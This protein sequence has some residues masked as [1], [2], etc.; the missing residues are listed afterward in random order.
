MRGGLGN[1]HSR[2]AVPDN[3]RRPTIALRLGCELAREEIGK[4]ATL[5]NAFPEI[6]RLHQSLNTEKC[7]TVHQIE[8]RAPPLA[9]HARR[10]YSEKLAIA[11]QQFREMVKQGICRPS[12]GSWASPILMKQKKD[13]T[14]RIC[15]DYHG[16]NADTE[17]DRYSVP[18]LQDFTANLHNKTIF[19]KLDLDKAYHQIPVAPEDISKTAVITPFG[20]FEYTVMTFGL[21]DAS[22]I[23][24]RYSFKDLRDL[25]YVFP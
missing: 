23:F 12:S 20:L 16:L 24:Q 19:S 6:T 25:P 3:R 15:G 1:L 17:P 5:L 4:Y 10:L 21:R 18:Y 14:W 7:D 8:T 22:Q 9:Q 13:G 11:K 2:C